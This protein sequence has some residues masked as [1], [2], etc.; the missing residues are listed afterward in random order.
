MEFITKTTSDIKEV[1][2]GIDFAQ[3]ELESKIKPLIQN[4]VEDIKE[5]WANSISAGAPFSWWNL[6]HIPVEILTKILLRKLGCSKLQAYAGSKVVSFLTAAG[7]SFFTGGSLD[8]VL[9]SVAVWITGQVLAIVK[10]ALSKG[11]RKICS[12]SLKLG[13]S[14]KGFT[15]ILQAILKLGKIAVS[16]EHENTE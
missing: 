10:V 4:A 2:D 3:I 1:I 6:I 15:N 9:G 14:S 5:N 12:G 16:S 8:G 13:I 11:F 7:I